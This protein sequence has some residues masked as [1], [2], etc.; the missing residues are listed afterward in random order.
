M[1]DLSD[2]YDHIKSYSIS[3]CNELILNVGLEVGFVVY[4]EFDVKNL[5]G[6][7]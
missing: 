4:K 5:I 7:G 1:T 2:G 6:R 3:R